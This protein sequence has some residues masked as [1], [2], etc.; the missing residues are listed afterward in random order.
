M[1]LAAAALVGCAAGGPH[2]DPEESLRP[3]I[4]QV[5]DA[6][7]GAPIEEAV[8]LDVFY[9]WP[10]RGVGNFPASKVFR[11]SAQARSDREGRFM[12]AGPHD[13]RS[14]WTESLHIFK[15]GYGPWR[16]RGQNDVAPPGAPEA[17]QWSWL[18]QTWDRI[19]HE[20]GRDRAATASNARGTPQVH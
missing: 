20:R 1:A 19:H 12:L 4:G 6:D 18:R 5:V 2:P 15:A 3:R 11:D 14:W 9:L 17:P 8:V 7:T 16:F 13:S 10:Q